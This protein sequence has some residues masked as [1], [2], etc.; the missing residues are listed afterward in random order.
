[1]ATSRPISLG[2]TGLTLSGLALS[3]WKRAN[4][5]AIP[6]SASTSGVAL[7]ELGD[8]LYYF[9]GLPDPQPNEDYSLS[10]ALSGSPSSIIATYDYG[11][12]KP[13]DLPSLIANTPGGFRF[14]QVPMAIKHGSTTPPAFAHIWGLTADPT[15]ATV[16]FALT[17]LGGG[18]AIA[19][20]GGVARV[21]FVDSYGAPPLWHMMIE[22]DW[23][24]GDLDADDV[25]TGI[26]VGAFTVT[27]P[28]AGGTVIS[29]NDQGRVAVS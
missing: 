16:A 10:I 8:S 17:P 5:D 1:M 6:V 20:M 14:D 26:Y 2:S 29:P 24:P 25:P 23:A 27:L 19:G 21:T 11:W 9:T 4:Q 12:T 15:G 28:S 13:V 7:V 18:S 3:F 22:F